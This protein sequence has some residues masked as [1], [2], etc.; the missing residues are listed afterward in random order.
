LKAV[1]LGHR[2]AKG[3]AESLV[4][5]HTLARET[6]NHYFVWSQL[7]RHYIPFRKYG[8]AA[9]ILMEGSK[10][11]EGWEHWWLIRGA[12]KFFAEEQNYDEAYN[13]VRQFMIDETS[14]EMRSDI[15]VTLAD[16]A[17]QQNASAVEMSA[18]E[19]ALEVDPTDASNRF[20]LGFLYS[21]Q[22]KSN[23]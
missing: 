8:E 2:A 10:Y 22:K 23:L 13:A 20:R 15:F 12:A 9:S 18:L 4:A 6:R 17:K 14:D 21:E 5:L 11:C 19:A 1:Y 16:I 3:H 7:G